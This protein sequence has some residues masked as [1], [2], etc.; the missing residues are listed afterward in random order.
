MRESRR[1]EGTEPMSAPS[2]RRPHD[3]VRRP[4]GGGT[5]HRYRMEHVLVGCGLALL[6]WLVVLAAPPMPGTGTWSGSAWTP[7]RPWA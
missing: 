4:T 2:D 6:P 3:A 5:R 7:W 1:R